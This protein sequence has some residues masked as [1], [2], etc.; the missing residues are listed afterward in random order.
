MTNPY[1]ISEQIKCIEREIEMRKRVYPR[2]II[3]GKMT[4]GQADREL[5]LMKHIYQTLVRIDR[6]PFIKNQ[7]FKEETTNV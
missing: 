2:L 7:L 5:N 6:H 1:D 3:N 4:Q